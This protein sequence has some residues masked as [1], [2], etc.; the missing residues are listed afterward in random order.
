MGIYEH[1]T[2]FAGLPVAEF[3]P[4]GHL[5]DKALESPASYAWAVRG[6]GDG[7]D[8]F[9][10]VW[11][12]FLRTVDTSGV[13]AIVVGYWS[14]YDEVDV[15]SLLAGSASALPALRALF[16]GDMTAEEMEI[17]WIHHVDTTPVFTAFPEL[18][19]VEIRGSAGLEFEPIVSDALR[20][21]RF[22]SGGLPASVVRTVGRSTL[23]NLEHLDMWLGVQEYL[24]DATVA[25][26][27]PF[28]S[29]TAFLRLR[30]LGLEDSEIQDEIAAAVAGAPVVAGLESL[31]L[32]MGLLTDTGAEALLS[33]Q[34]LTHLKKLDLHYHFC[35]E[36]M[37]ERV[38]AALPGVAVD[39]DDRHVFDPD[40][41]FY[42]EVSE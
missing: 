34:P 5:S 37:V 21:L 28:L 25:D 23:P 42:V 6:M 8:D 20:V 9:G 17:S 14:P 36:E 4:S 1:L 18:E 19:R 30:H 16:V 10:T 13:T 15:P 35:S 38:R 3:G 32:A 7:V 33:G 22:E 40:D 12:N 27:E 41:G 11:A 26:L 2:E 31:S 24:G 29:G 39:L